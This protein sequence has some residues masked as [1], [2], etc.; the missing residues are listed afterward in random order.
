MPGGRSQFGVSLVSLGGHHLSNS[1]SVFLCRQRGPS[2]V[3]ASLR[4][5]WDDTGGQDG[6]RRDG[7]PATRSID[8]G[9][10]SLGAARRRC[11]WGVPGNELTAFVAV[12]EHCSFTKAAAHVGIALPTM[13]QTIQSFEQRLGVRLFNRT[14]RSVVASDS[15]RPGTAPFRPGSSPRATSKPRS[16]S[17]ARIPSMTLIM[18]CAALSRGSALPTSRSL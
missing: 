16:L 13:S 14:T 9:T 5:R 18:S 17:T 12:S 6:L 3:H 15:A 11:S 2:R 4:A 10:G 8:V 7:R 1:V